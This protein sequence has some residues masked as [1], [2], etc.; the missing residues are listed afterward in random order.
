MC[1]IRGMLRRSMALSHLAL[2]PPFFTRSDLAEHDR[3]GCQPH[4]LTIGAADD[5]TERDPPGRRPAPVD[6]IQAGPVDPPAAGKVGRER[7]LAHAAFG[8]RI[9]DPSNVV[10]TDLAKDSHHVPP[11]PFVDTGVTC[12]GEPGAVH[13]LGEAHEERLAPG[14]RRRG[15]VVDVLVVT[16]FGDLG[17]RGF[18]RFP[19]DHR[20]GAVIPDAVELIEDERR[21]GPVL[22]NEDRRRGA[23]DFRIEVVDQ[24]GIVVSAGYE[25]SDGHPSSMGAGGRRGDR[26]GAESQAGEHSRKTKPGRHAAT[27]RPQHDERRQ[28]KY[29]GEIEIRDMRDPRIER[30]S[31]GNSGPGRE[32]AKQMGRDPGRESQPD[33]AG[34]ATPCKP[35]GRQRH[36]NQRPGN[37]CRDG[38]AS[39]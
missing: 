22:V 30:P 24:R 3:P 19:G 5:L 12:P 21:L 38:G 26:D 29:Q 1:C 16:A 25:G 20:L 28:P 8:V 13:L 23:P 9:P 18:P 31:K 34:G 2:L 17:Q 39:P 14:G 32:I 4:H 7:A 33:Q 15:R 36:H 37:A 11:G 35:S 10:G 27:T 6:D